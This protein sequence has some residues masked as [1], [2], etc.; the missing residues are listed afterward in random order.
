MRMWLM[1]IVKCAI[2][3]SYYYFRNYLAILLLESLQI[4]Y[5]KAKVTM[6]VRKPLLSNFIAL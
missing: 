1:Y 2:N 3:G 6:L 4:N 5:S